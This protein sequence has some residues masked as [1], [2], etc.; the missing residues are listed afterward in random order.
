MADLCGYTGKILKVDLSA[1]NYSVMNTADYLPDFVGGRGIGAKIHWDLVGPDVQAFDPENVLTLMT[2][3]QAGIMDTRL[4]VQGVSPLGYPKECYYRSSMGSHFGA[5]L[6][7]AGWDGIVLT[8]KASQLS[9][10]VIR[11][12]DVQI[13][14]ATD[15]YQ[16]DTYSTSYNMWARFGNKCRILCIGPAGENMVADAIIQGDDHNATGLGGFGGVMGS[17]NVKA[18]VCRGTLDSPPIYNVDEFM[19]LRLEEANLMV[20]NP[21]VGAAAG[22]EI[23]LAGQTGLARCGVAGCFGCQQPCGYAIKYKDGKSVA[24][25]SIKCGEFICSKA[26]LQQTGEY[27]GRNHYIRVAQQGLLGLSGQPSYKRVIQ[28]DVKN[29]YDEPLMCI[30]EGYMTEA[31]LGIPYTYGTPEFTDALNRM[32]AYRTGVGDELAKGMPRFCNEYVGTDAA[33]H[34]YQMNSM[35]QGMHGF[36]VGFYIH[37]YRTC[38]MLCRGTSTVNSA[39]QRGQYHYLF[40]MYEFFQ[41]DDPVAVGEDMANWGWTYTAKGVRNMQDLKTSIDL[42]GRCYFNIGA[43]SMGVYQHYNQRLFTAITGQEYYGDFENDAVERIWVLER[44][45]LERQGHTREDDELLDVVFDEFSAN[46]SDKVTRANYDTA[47]EQYYEMRNVD[48]ATGLVRRSE[49]ERLGLADV[50]DRLESEYGITLPA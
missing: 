9:V 22:S 6:K 43:D 26:E 17:K 39:D 30:H 42:T 41:E 33:I 45:I 11:N 8:G 29:E 46:Y 13:I 3:A 15:L 12:D 23:E 35:R 21:G 10:I 14:K 44:S 25:G 48:P 37:L 31:D 28:D 36:G 16:M 40:P 50:A 19:Q 34:D 27:V 7:H 49:Y 20:P 18:I 32:I 2:G 4:V 5:E 1:E 38:G 47:L 24:M